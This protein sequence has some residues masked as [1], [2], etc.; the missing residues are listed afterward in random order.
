MN[1]QQIAT[2]LKNVAASYTISDEKKYRFQIIAYQKAADAISGQTSE[3]N[4]LVKENRLEH[5]PGVGKS[6]K[7]HLEE[8]IKTGRV[9]HFD[10]ITKQIPKSVFPL[11]EIPNLGPKT[12]YKIVKAFSLKNADTVID[13]TEN[14]AK[15]KKIQ[16]LEGFGE[17]SQ[18]VI[19]QTIKEYKRGKTKSS[20]MPLP[21]A[22]EIAEK[23]LSHLKKSSSIIEAVPLGSLRR[24]M[25]TVGDV[26]IA[27]ATNEPKKAIEHFVSYPYKH[28]ILEQGS[29][30]ASI[31]TSAGKQVDLMAQDPT[32]FGALLQHFTGSKSHNVH[33]REHCLKIGL[34]LSEHG[35]KSVSEPSKTKRYKKEEEFY[36]ALK[37]DWIPPEMRENTGE[38]ELAIKHKL[39]KLVELADIKG[40]LHIH[41]NFP[42]EP[43]HDMGIDSMKDMLK[44]GQNLKYEYLGFSE[45]NPSV[46]RHTK[47]QIYSIITRRNEYIEQIKSQIKSVRVIKLL[48]ID[49]L[50]NGNLAVDNKSL[51]ILD[52]AIVSIHSSFRMKKEDMT[53]RV[54]EG[55]SHPKAKILAHPTGR[56]LNERSGYELDFEKIFD[57]CIENN[58][59]LEINSWP[60]RLDLPD[61][62]IRQAIKYKVKCIINTDSHAASQ[63]TLM[64][65]GVAMGRRGW[66]TKND[67]TNTLGYNDFIKWLKS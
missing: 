42:M 30:T 50:V 18:E 2:L 57:F 54:I 34:S 23:V 46:S 38:I 60:N 19:L 59:A 1:N 7:S 25:P 5:L 63:M 31:L 44:V 37:M 62:L 13:D 35:I 12:A 22:F 43:S 15:N 11:L 48:E 6:I 36:K 55:F 28:R 20:R 47:T 4:D 33:L 10:K 29:A 3:I 26:D 21:Y 67:I 52:A 9:K 49:I 8:L 56:M 64:R 66:A 32:S 65:Y 51:A 27:V 40:D 53:K 14:L 17:K 24:M 16:S 58:K 41:S 45:H 39:P 61:S